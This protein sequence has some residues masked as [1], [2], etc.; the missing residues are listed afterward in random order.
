[1]HNRTLTWTRSFTHCSDPGRCRHGMINKTISVYRS[2]NYG[3]PSSSSRHLAVKWVAFALLP[4]KNPPPACR[5]SSS[6]CKTM[7][8]TF[9]SVIQFL[10]FFTPGKSVI[11]LPATHPLSPCVLLSGFLYPVLLLF[12]LLLFSLALIFASVLYDFVG[13][14]ITKSSSALRSCKQIRTLLFNCHL[15]HIE[16][17]ALLFPLGMGIV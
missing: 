3:T 11:F 15:L 1:M 5:A 13:L 10:D 16:L 2:I 12:D 6:C 4:G 7:N 14:K 9:I 8:E 17:P